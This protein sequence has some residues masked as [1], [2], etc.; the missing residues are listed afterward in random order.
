[1]SV[2]EAYM[3]RALELAARGRGVTSPNPLVGA[4]VVKDGRVVAEAFHEGAGRRHAEAVALD[5]AGDEARDATL[6]VN[7]EPCVHH[8]RT[9]PCAPRVIESGVWRVVVA[10]PDPNPLVDGRGFR[11][12]RDA[13]IEVTT[14]VLEHESRRLNEAFLTHVRTG[15]PFVTLKMAAS[16]DGKVAARDGSSRW[17]TGGEAREDVHRMRAEVDAIMVGAGTAFRDDPSL[18]VRVAGYHGRGKLRVLVDGR[19]IVPESHRLFA[20]GGAPT[21]V[22]TTEGA[23]EDRRRAWADA[24]ADVVVIDDDGRSLIELDALFRELGKRDVQH[25]LLE[26]GPTLAWEAVRRDLVDRVVLFFAPIFVGGDRAPSVLMGDGTPTIGEA[27]PVAIESVERVGDD[28][29]VVARVHRD[30]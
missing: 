18:T 3:R 23:P 21:L 24:G 22:A 14:G 20:E 25:V 7:L 8:G 6:Y 28:I 15:R 17:I 13:G 12:L 27:R 9:P 11:A 26:G 2:D 10:M 4:V 30:H 16:L 1:M 19:G 5:A 29:K